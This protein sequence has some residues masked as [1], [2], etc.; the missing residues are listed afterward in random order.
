MRKKTC[1]SDQ[2][3]IFFYCPFPPFSCWGELF[4]CIIFTN[5]FVSLIMFINSKGFSNVSG[6]LLGEEMKMSLDAC[7]CSCKVTPLCE[8]TTVL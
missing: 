6:L 5:T 8:V 1:A 2:H 3:Y 7:M 4:R